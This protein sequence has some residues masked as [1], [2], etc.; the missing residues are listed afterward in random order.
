MLGWKRGLAITGATCVT[1]T[2][3][4]LFGNNF[5]RAFESDRPSASHGTWAD[6]SLQHGKRLPTSGEN[7]AAYSRLGAT[8]GRNSVHGTVRDIVTDAYAAV[9][10]T[11]PHVRFVYGET[12]WPSG[13]RF[14]PHR[15][16]RNGLSVDFMVPVRNAR[17]EP[18]RF[19]TPPWTRFGYDL[20]FDSTGAAGDLHIDF[21]AVSAH[22]AALR[23]AAAERG[24]GIRIVIFAP[25]LE[26]RM[27]AV[28]GAHARLAG[29]TFMRGRPWVRHDEHYHV[30]FVLPPT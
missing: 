26:T 18:I 15:T 2:V 21:D 22:L 4:A 28:P 6:G 17:G 20:E 3:A 16:H 14:R 29:I 7:F 27:R 5:A 12:G 8:L 25:E 11:H 23:E 1:L 24:A 9:A 30:D 13:G 10:K 19:P